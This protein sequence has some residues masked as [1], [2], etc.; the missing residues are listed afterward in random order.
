MRAPSFHIADSHLLHIGH[1][2]ID[3]KYDRIFSQ[4][5]RIETLRMWIALSPNCSASNRLSLP[6]VSFLDV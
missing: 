6:I 2:N 1:S 5:S 3:S 4:S